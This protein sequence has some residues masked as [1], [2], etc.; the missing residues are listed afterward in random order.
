MDIVP[1]KSEYPFYY[2]NDELPAEWD[3]EYKQTVRRIK[4]NDMYLSDIVIACSELG[5]HVTQDEVLRTQFYSNKFKLQF[6]RDW[7][8]YYICPN[9]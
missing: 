8:H 5:V 9:K 6:N 1:L 4:V 7:I 2:Y 3:T